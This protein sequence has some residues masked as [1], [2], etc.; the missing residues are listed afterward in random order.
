MA[1][2]MGTRGGAFAQQLRNNQSINQSIN[3]HHQ[4]SSSS[5]PPIDDDVTTTSDKMSTTFIA[6]NTSK[7]QYPVS[8]P[9]PSIGAALASAPSSGFAPLGGCHPNIGAPLTALARGRAF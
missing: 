9:N 2:V 3:H 5:P 8:A 1:N 4:V 6:A 7:N